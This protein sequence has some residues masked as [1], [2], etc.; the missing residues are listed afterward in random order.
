[1]PYLGQ[2]PTKG[3]ENNFKILD[4]I[5]SYTLTFD[6]SDA[7]VVSAAN[8]TITSLSHRF[9]QGQRV[10]YNKGGGTVITG[11]SDGVYY[12]IKHDHNTI[13]LA[14]SASNAAN[15]I[16]VNITNVGS[17]SSHT[18]N[19]AFDGVNTKFKATHTNGQKARITRSAQLVISING[20]IQQPHDSATP[21][22][23]F[24]FDLDGTIVLSQAPVAGDV[25]WAHVLTNNNVTF[26]ISDNDVD[27]F[28]GNGSTVSFNL[29]KTPPDNRNVLV[30]IDGVVQ[31]PNDPDGTV[32]AYTVVENVLTFTVAP[33]A[34]VQI[35]VRH[36]GFAGSTSGGGGVTNFYGRTGS[37]TLINTDNIVANNAEFAGNLTVQGTMTT[38]DTKVT[39]VDQLEVAANNTTVGVAITQSGTG[40]ILNLYDGSTER[41]S[42]ADGGVTSLK[43]T[44]DYQGLLINGNI[45]PT[46]RFATFNNTTPLWK[47]GLSGNTGDTFAI[48]DGATSNDRLT[49]NATHTTINGYL[50]TGSISLDTKLY[51][52]G[53]TNNFIE[54]GTDIQ[55]FYTNNSERVKITNTGAKV[56]GKL[57]V[58]VDP[59]EYLDIRTTGSATALVGSTN[60]GGAYFKLDGDSNGDGSGSDYARLV[61]DTSGVFYIDNFKTANISFRNTS[62]LIER[63]RIDNLGHTTI[64]SG[65]HDKGLD[66]LATANSRETKFR[67]QGKA[68]DGTEHN[69]YF[70][71]KASGNRLD[72]SGTGPMCF[73]GTQNVGVQ[74]TNPTSPLHVGG[75][76]NNSGVKATLFVGAATGDG[77]FHLRGDSPTVFFDKSGSGYAKIL[78]DQADLSISNGILGNTGTELVRITT[79]GNLG[80]GITNP[81]ERL[82]VI[83]DVKIG[84]P[85][86]TARNLIISADRAANTDLGN[87]IAKNSGGNIGAISFNT[88]TR[89]QKD[90]GSIDFRTSPHSGQPLL[91]VMRLTT[92]RQMIFGITEA[93]STVLG[94]Y[95]PKVQIEATDVGGSS[96]FLNRDGNDHGGCYLFLGHGRG[97][98][99]LVQD[100][101]NLGNLM[102][103]GGTGSNFRGAANISCAVDVPSGGSV[104]ASS[105]PGALIFSTSNNNQNSPVEAMRIRPD[106]RIVIGGSSAV[107]FTPHANADELVIGATS[108]AN[109]GITILT[110]TNNRGCLYFA[111]TNDDNAGQIDYNQGNHYMTF[112]TNG[113][114]RVV[115]DNAGNLIIDATSVGN[116]STYARNI[117]ISGSSN[118]GMTIHTTDT[119]G[120]NRKCCIFFGDGTSVPDMATGMLF[121][122]HNGDYLHMSANGGGTGFARSARLNSDGTFRLDS[123]PSAVNSISL[124]IQSHKTRT[125]NDNNGIAFFD[126][127]NHTQAAIFVSKQSTSA[128]TSDLVFSTSSGQVVSTLQGIPERMRIKS[129][130]TSY[131]LGDFG[132]GTNSPQSAGL[133]VEN[134]SEARLRVRAGSNA[135]NG[136]VALRADGGNTQ[137][138]T[139]SDHDLKLVRNTT[140]VASLNANGI[141][142]PSGYGIDFSATSDASGGSS[143]LLDDYEEGT[144]TAT[145]SSGVTI[146]SY[147]SQ[148]GHYTKIGNQVFAYVYILATASSS[149]SNNLIVSGLPFV[150]NNTVLHEG[151]GYITYMNGTF[152][153]GGVE[154]Q[155]MPWVPQNTSYVNFHTPEDGNN[156]R[157]DETNFANK[158]LIFH[159]RYH[160]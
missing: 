154:L 86:N 114:G 150:N 141:A 106:G 34:D 70:N 122:D 131:V 30:T 160:V 44:G 5:S 115:I 16:A 25:Y 157:G 81:D 2:A 28:T 125:V 69:F 74:N 139:W 54:F 31:Y 68:S 95:G 59:V 71:A 121:Y 152:G 45:C 62:S 105:M 56:T 21:S 42:V 76:A 91:R 75:S 94:S 89:S 63:L 123:T 98:N 60:A 118:N 49:V 40:D 67:I 158:Y 116:A 113:E 24:G 47:A 38:L 83:G 64:Y 29:S 129:D 3:D 53:D 97:G 110:G 48:S 4:N 90:D 12:I 10:T 17:G 151:G 148:V 22:T 136:E 99:G 66:L 126:E 33:A 103:V 144:F 85:V 78:T 143:E 32:R 128:G 84:S 46:V 65:A 37:V 23:G 8:D 20:V 72:M 117:V 140:E 19:V 35:Q 88:G 101:D 93:H 120:V 36:I 124:R 51:H 111:D 138:G 73:I 55:Y 130:G 127:V 159:V 15:G 27:N 109:R 9:V 52:T 50:N 145:I 79:G 132:V 11:L 61:H 147:N 142:F 149:N 58:G 1:M 100:G 57:G 80:I 119:S 112:S 26:D 134:S 156:I 87:I 135:S 155:A 133:T 18:L 146:S 153:T 43:A 137:L 39:E 41:F 92:G 77:M 107:S 82:Q 108:N 7:A 96:L 13:K 14:T 104:S 102:F 6:G